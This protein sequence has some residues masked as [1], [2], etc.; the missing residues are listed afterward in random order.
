MCSP[1]KSSIFPIENVVFFVDYDMTEKYH[2][3]IT[4]I[5]AYDLSRLSM[6]ID[7]HVEEERIRLEKE[8]HRLSLQEACIICT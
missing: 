6:G 7:A 5:V 8:V 1:K 4:N 2:L 3:G